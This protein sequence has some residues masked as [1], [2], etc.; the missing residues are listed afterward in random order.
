MAGQIALNKASGGQMIIAPQD[1]TTSETI[2]LPTGGVGKIRQV[3]TGIFTSSAGNTS[4]SNS[5]SFTSSGLALTFDQDLAPGS[6][7]YCSFSVTFGQTDATS[8]WA[9][10]THVTI[11]E[12][13]VNRGDSATG[14][15]TGNGMAGSGGSTMQYELQRISGDVLFT[16]STISTPTC[17]LFYR[18][19]SSSI[20]SY[21]NRAGSGSA[22]YYSS[23]TMT[24]MEV[25]Q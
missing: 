4:V 12:G 24:I 8:A 1:G 9:S 25:T 10:P 16:P 18:S 17:F 20:T 19:K 13:G 6:K 5:T 11:F 21:I 22:E 14:L 3:K 15:A 2:V 23:S 7:V